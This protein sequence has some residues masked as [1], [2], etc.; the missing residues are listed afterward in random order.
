MKHLLLLSL[1]CLLLIPSGNLL[2]AETVG[3][4]NQAVQGR[5]MDPYSASTPQAA[6]VIPPNDKMIHG[7]RNTSFVVL[8]SEPRLESSPVAVLP[9]DVKFELLE[10]LTGWVKVRCIQGTGYIRDMYFAYNPSGATAPTPPTTS[11][12]NNGRIS[13]SGSTPPVS[14]TPAAPP[15]TAKGGKAL[16]GWLQSAGLTGETLRMAWSIAMGESGG[17]P[18]AFNGNSRTGDKSYGLFQI[19]MIGSMGPARLKQF[20]LT[21]NDQLFDPMTNIKAMMKV[22]SNCKNW[23]PW[24][25][26]K[27]GTYKKYYSQFPPK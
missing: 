9:F 11:G 26:Y 2:A 17:N 3:G 12:S 1:L 5:S 20:G 24:S 23:K 25:V 7:L 13:D 22:S 18:R 10:R 8:R 19:N 21:S 4:L 15:A 6:I 14:S 27:H 16:L